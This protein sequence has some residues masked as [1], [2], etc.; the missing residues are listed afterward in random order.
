MAARN[1]NSDRI[2]VE[3]V[4]GLAGFGGA[5]LKSAGQVALAD[6]PAADRHALEGLF[7][8]MQVHSP[9]PDAFVYRI[10]RQVGGTPQTIEVSEEHVPAAV[11][12]CVKTTLA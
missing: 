10:T 12:Q 8:A 3:R 6:L 7:R 1:D 9:K 2:E 11:R 4:G 5:R